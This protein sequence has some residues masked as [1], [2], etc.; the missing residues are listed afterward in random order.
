MVTAVIHPVPLTYLGFAM[1]DNPRE[2]GLQRASCI[3]VGGRITN[4][5]ANRYRRGIFIAL[6]FCF[7]LVVN[8]GFTSLV[9]KMLTVTI[10]QC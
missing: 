7:V 4:E 3:T 2:I 10:V 8:T 9:Q 6:V 5:L 1:R